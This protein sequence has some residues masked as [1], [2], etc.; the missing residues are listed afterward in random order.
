[1]RMSPAEFARLLN[2]DVRSVYR[3]ESG[4]ST[5]SGTAESVL[6]GIRQA[7]AAGTDK[8]ANA[9]AIVGGL[10]VLGGLGLLVHKLIEVLSASD[11]AT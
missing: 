5:P 11:E 2:V 8:V 4:E 1:M 9:L 7:M 6:L 10:A 3:W